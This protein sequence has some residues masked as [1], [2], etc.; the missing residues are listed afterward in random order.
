M[1]KPVLK[2]DKTYSFSDCFDL[3]RPMKEIPEFFG[4]KYNFEELS[5]SNLFSVRGPA[6]LFLDRR[7]CTEL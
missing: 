6:L 7:F 2:K 5:G 1:K 3:N 4:Y